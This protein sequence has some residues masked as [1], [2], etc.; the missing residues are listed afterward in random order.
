MGDKYYRIIAGHI[1]TNAPSFL[2]FSLLSLPSSLYHP[3]S[4]PLLSLPSSPPPAY[5]E[6]RCLSPCPQPSPS[7]AVKGTTPAEGTTIQTT[8]VTSQDALSLTP[9]LLVCR[10]YNTCLHTMVYPAAS[11]ENRVWTLSLGSKLCLYTRKQPCRLFGIK[12]STSN[13]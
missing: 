10:K 1:P 9:Y 13:W 12:T 7:H 3:Y 4:S 8:S 6:C 2:Y 11:S 5:H